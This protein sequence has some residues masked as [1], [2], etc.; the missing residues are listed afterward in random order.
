MKGTDPN[1]SGETRPDCDTSGIPI[2]ADGSIAILGLIVASA[3]LA[4]DNGPAVLGGVAVGLP[5]SISAAVGEAKQK[6]CERQIEEWQIGTTIGTAAA[7]RLGRQPE[8]PAPSEAPPEPTN[9]ANDADKAWAF[10]CSPSNGQ[11]VADEALCVGDCYKIKRVWCAWGEKRWLCS[12]SHAACVDLRDSRRGQQ[13]NEC[14]ERTAKLQPPTPVAVE[15]PKA[16]QP[17]VPAPRGWFCFAS[18][19]QAGVGACVR[20]KAECEAARDAALGAVADISMC[21]LIE[22]GWCF[23]ADGRTRCAP[24]AETCAAQMSRAQNVSVTCAEQR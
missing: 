10:W 18:P 12:V 24:S 23:V 5:F 3:G 2:V 6:K 16:R 4:A 22:S 9:R 8:A 20:E 13:Y 7:A 14:I 17:V 21:T 19:S 15:G 11:C 1:W